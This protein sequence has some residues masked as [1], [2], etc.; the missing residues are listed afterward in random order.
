M[1]RQ[2]SG[3]D[4]GGRARIS[5]A[6]S[7]T[8]TDEKTMNVIP[9][10]KLIWFFKA[11][12]RE[13]IVTVEALCLM[14]FSAITAEWTLRV[15][16]MWWTYVSDTLPVLS[17]K[18]QRFTSGRHRRPRTHIVDSDSKQ[19]RA[20]YVHH[21]CTVCSFIDL[22]YHLQYITLAG[23]Y[24][25]WLL[26]ELLVNE[27][28]R[29]VPQYYCCF[30][31]TFLF[32]FRVMGVTHT[33]ESGAYL[34]YQRLALNR[35]AIC[36]EQVSG[37]RKYLCNAA[38]HTLSYQFLVPDSWACVTPRLGQDSLEN[39]C[40]LLQLVFYSLDVLL[41]QPKALHKTSIGTVVL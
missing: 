12:T 16:I 38:W 25:S 7:S 33:Q 1:G 6:T 27:Y 24:G 31:T 34:W 13:L 4:F 2:S 22:V 41:V 8:L 28:H 37:I 15:H 3:E 32:L 10:H 14:L 36:L 39:L 5:L 19:L 35:A 20:S 40:G 21:V 9:I 11:V 18:S 23:E 17:W 26:V 30:R 29:C